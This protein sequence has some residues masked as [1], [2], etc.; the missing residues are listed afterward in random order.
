M[1][2]H[3]LHFQH[4]QAEMPPMEFFYVM[5]SG[6]LYSTIYITAYSPYFIVFVHWT[7]LL[8]YGTHNRR[9]YQRASPLYSCSIY[10]VTLC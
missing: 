8:K 1:N 4:Q 2:T 10:R 6:G 7:Q 5:A 3:L 9:R